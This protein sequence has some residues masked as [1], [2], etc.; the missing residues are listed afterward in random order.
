[1]D[2]DGGRGSAVAPGVLQWEAGR[3]WKQ[4]TDT[5][6]WSTQETFWEE[7]D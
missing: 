1:M 3:G 7:A 5:M 6:R 2:K 4:E